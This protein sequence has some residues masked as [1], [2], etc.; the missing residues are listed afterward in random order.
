MKHKASKKEPDAR[1]DDMWTWAVI[2][3]IFFAVALSLFGPLVWEVTH[4]AL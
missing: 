2:G 4:N 1:D 3:L